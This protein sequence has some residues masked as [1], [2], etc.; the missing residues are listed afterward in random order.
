MTKLLNV[1]DGLVPLL[2]KKIIFSTNLENLSKIDA[3]IMRPGRCFDT[4]VFRQLSH[5][6]AIRACDRAGLEHVPNRH[7]EYTLSEIFNGKNNSQ[8]QKKIGF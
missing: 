6:E 5:E 3:A 4:V 7:K 2:R 8:P 1:S